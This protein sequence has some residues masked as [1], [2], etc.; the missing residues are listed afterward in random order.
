MGPE[1]PREFFYDFFSQTQINIV[2][3]TC[4]ENFGP[5]PC[6]MAILGAQKVSGR[7]PPP[8]PGTAN[9]PTTWD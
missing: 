8:P 7:I 3:G 2:V 9:L 1:E 6:P 5:L 4:G